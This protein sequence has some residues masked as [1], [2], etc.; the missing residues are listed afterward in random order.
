[1]QSSGIPAK[2]QTPFGANATSG[3]IRTIPQTTGDP[4]AASLSIGFP[5]NTFSPP[6]AGGVEP[7]G[8]DVNGILRAVSSWAQWQQAGG[9]TIYDS[10]FS[11]QIGGYPKGAIL[12]SSV[13]AGLFWCST[14]DNNTSNPDASGANWSAMG[15]VAIASAAAAAQAAAI[16]ASQPLNS[17]LTALAANVTTDGSGSFTFPHA[18]TMAALQAPI[19]TASATGLIVTNNAG[20]PDTK[21]D[22]TVTKAVLVNSSGHPRLYSG[23]T[24]TV[25]LAT[26]GANGLDTGLKANSTWYHIYLISNGTT[27]ASLASTSATSPALPGSYT[28]FMRVGAMQTDG[29]GNL[30]RTIQKGHDARY[31]ITATTNTASFPFAKSGSS[32][33]SWVAQQVTGNGYAAPGTAESVIVNIGGYIGSNSLAISVAPN[34]NY[35]PVV[36]GSPSNP[37]GAGFSGAG[38]I[39]GYSVFSIANVSLESNS[40]YYW[41]SSI[42]G[43]AEMLGWTDTLS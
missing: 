43:L 22:V 36:T 9:L 27:T 20:T 34:A 21:A 39:A 3:C 23:G 25:N 37:V 31:V 30:Y 26:T 33:S 28:Y 8:R 2:F 14:A 42:Y 11:S 16:A 10:T 24:L 18:V 19:A 35:N 6:G 5:P 32:S 29:S 38:T 17:L 40:I 7:D 13:T 1:M 4:N 41:S 15:A 12:A